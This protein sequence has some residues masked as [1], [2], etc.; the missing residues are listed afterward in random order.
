MVLVKVDP[1]AVEVIGLG[2]VSQLVDDD[3]ITVEEKEL[4]MSWALTIAP[5]N[6]IK[7]TNVDVGFICLFVCYNFVY[8]S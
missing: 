6:A 7:E 3:K 1:A 8:G 5:A 2:T 4:T